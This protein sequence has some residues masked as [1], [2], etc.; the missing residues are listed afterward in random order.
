[1]VILLFCF[2]SLNFNFR[3]SRKLVLNNKINDRRKFRCCARTN[4]KHGRGSYHWRGKHEE[5]QEE[6][7][8]IEVEKR[9]RGRPKGAVGKKTKSEEEKKKNGQ[10]IFG[11]FI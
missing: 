10:G 7:K 11:C 1:M 4:N 6:N 2:L 8:Q 5:K 3:A 9:A